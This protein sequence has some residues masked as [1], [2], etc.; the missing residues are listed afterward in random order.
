MTEYNG[1]WTAELVDEDIGDHVIKDTDDN[2]VARVSNEYIDY[3]LAVA[4]WQDDACPI[5]AHARLIASAP[6]LLMACQFVLKWLGEP[7]LEESEAANTSFKKAIKAC[8]S[9]IAHTTKE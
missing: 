8:R 3:D 4:H 9:A 5:A 2:A 1:P 6:E 7:S